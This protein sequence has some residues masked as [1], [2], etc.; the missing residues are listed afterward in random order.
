MS[1]VQAI[2]NRQMVK[3]DGRLLRITAGAYKNKYCY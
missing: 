1:V 2:F 3:I